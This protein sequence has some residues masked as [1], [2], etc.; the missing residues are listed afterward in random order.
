MKKIIMTSLAVI[1]AAGAVC[2][3]EMTVER[4]RELCNKSDK[5]VWVESDTACVPID[6]CDKNNYREKYCAGSF[7]GKYDIS[8][9][10]NKMEIMGLIGSY[11]RYRIGLPNGCSNIRFLQ[12]GTMIYAVCLSAEKMVAFSMPERQDGIHEVTIYPDMWCRALGKG[13]Y[14][15]AQKSNGEIEERCTGLDETQCLKWQGDG[16]QGRWDATSAECVK[17]NN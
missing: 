13:E 15:L 2:A 9:E 17:V 1:F 5:K 3:A 16:W 6:A 8:T 4:K 11:A 10:E 12:K 14:G 7:F